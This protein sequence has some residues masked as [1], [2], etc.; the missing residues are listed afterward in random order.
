[1]AKSSEDH[2]LRSRIDQLGQDIA[3]IRKRHAKAGERSADA[4]EL[5]KLA[6]RHADLHRR[7][8]DFAARSNRDHHIAHALEA[9]C[10]GL[11]QSINRWISRQ[12][13]KTTRD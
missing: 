5:S 2:G 4:S 11:M 12:D 7:L 6:S 8:A 10:D 1:M 13:A 9:D 3:I